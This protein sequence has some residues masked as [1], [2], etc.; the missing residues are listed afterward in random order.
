MVKSH[1]HLL[2][3]Y[4]EDTD[5]SGFTY[6][7]SY[8]KFLERG[9]TE[10]LRALGLVQS[11]LYSEGTAFVVSRMTLDYLRPALMDD[12]LTVTTTLRNLK[13]ASMVLAQDISRDATCLLRAEVVVAAVRRGRAVRLPEALRRAFAADATARGED[14]TSNGEDRDARRSEGRSSVDKLAMRHGFGQEAVLSLAAAL[15]R[16]GGAQ[17]QFSHPEFGGMGQWS[18]GGMIMIGDMFNHE[19]KA[20]VDALCRDLAEADRGNGPLRQEASGGGAPGAWWPSGLGAP[21]SSGSQNGVEYAWFP[22]ARRLAL[23]R[24]GRLALFDTGDHAISG[25]SQAQGATSDLLFTSQHGPVRLRDLAPTDEAD[26]KTLQQGARQTRPASPGGDGVA[27]IE[28]LHGLSQ[29]GILTEAE[30]AAK[31]KELLDRL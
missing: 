4:Y 25:V 29:K 17:A 31:K 12:V 28:A 7:A 1:L 22:Q 11:E 18:R 27:A 15:E 3:V 5:F 23:R 30:Y 21:G 19:L 20:R 2:R 14:V 26:P 8:L 13:G 10:F 24:E 6:H 16:G 9:R